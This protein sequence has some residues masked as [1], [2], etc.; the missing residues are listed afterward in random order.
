MH[1]QAKAKLALSYRSSASKPALVE[2]AKRANSPNQAY[3][4]AY[5]EVGDVSHAKACQYLAMI[6]RDYGKD[7]FDDFVSSTVSQP[8]TT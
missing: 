3:R 8:P 1:L 4:L 5:L 6:K 2:I 7:A